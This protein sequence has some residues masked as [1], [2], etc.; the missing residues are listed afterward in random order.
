MGRGGLEG[1]DQ[2]RWLGLLWR[3][4]LDLLPALRSRCAGLVGTVASPAGLVSCGLLPLALAVDLFESKVDGAVR[5]GRWLLVTKAGAEQL[6][7]TVYEN[8]A[9]ALLSSPPW[10]SGVIASAELGWAYGG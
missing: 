7:G 3:V 5:F 4:D 9:K 8:W 10:R 6:L 1:V 2:H